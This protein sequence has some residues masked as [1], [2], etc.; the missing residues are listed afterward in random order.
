M[1]TLFCHRITYRVYS[2]ALTFYID[3]HI[4]TFKVLYMYVYIYIYI[5]NVTAEVWDLSLPVKMNLF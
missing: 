2:M 1:P 5:Y 3:I 4:V